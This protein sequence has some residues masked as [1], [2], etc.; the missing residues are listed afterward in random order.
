M[1][2][3]CALTSK[4]LHFTLILPPPSALFRNVSFH[5][6]PY[7]LQYLLPLDQCPYLLPYLLRKLW[8]CQESPPPQSLPLS[9]F[10]IR[11]LVVPELQQNI[12]DPLARWI[13]RGP[14]PAASQTKHF[15]CRGTRAVWMMAVTTCFVKRDGRGEVPRGRMVAGGACSGGTHKEGV[16]IQSSRVNAAWV[17]RRLGVYLSN[18][19]V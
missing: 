12:D 4:L 16:R 6:P 1:S 3:T 14:I 17:L 15:V 13:P 18:P 9:T 10:R 8:L 5:H 11:I 7:P 19:R 2:L